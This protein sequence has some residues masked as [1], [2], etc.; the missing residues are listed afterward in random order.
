MKNREYASRGIPF[1]YSECDSDFDDKDYVIKAPADESPIDVNCI[2]DFME[3]FSTPASVI[4]E[5]VKS[6]SWE[7]QMQRV[8]EEM[9]A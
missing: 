5:S 1:I 2:I 4:R 9:M 3:H 6:L 7:S 8:V